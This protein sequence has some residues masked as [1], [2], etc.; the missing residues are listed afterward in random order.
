ML[1]DDTILHLWCH[2]EGLTALE[3]LVVLYICQW[4]CYVVA[5]A[6]RILLLALLRHF[7]FPCTGIVTILTANA[8]CH[9]FV[10]Q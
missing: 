10:I 4:L 6:L 9:F 7:G 5:A 3:T 1:L 8:I 2:G